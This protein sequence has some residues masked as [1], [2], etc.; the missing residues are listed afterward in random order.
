MLQNAEGVSAS[1]LLDDLGLRFGRQERLTPLLRDSLR[2]PWTADPKINCSADHRGGRD[3]WSPEPP[4]LV[5]QSGSQRR[6]RTPP[7][8]P[9]LPRCDERV[10]LQLDIVVYTMP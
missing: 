1:P 5:V 2:S 10:L 3:K 6:L 9:H 7:A 4:C 8:Y